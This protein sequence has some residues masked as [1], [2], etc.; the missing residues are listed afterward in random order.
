MGNLVNPLG[1]WEIGTGAETGWSQ[2]GNTAENTRIYG[3]NPWKQKAVIWTSQWDGILTGTPPYE[4]TGEGESNADGGFLSGYVPCDPT[5]KYRFSWWIN[6]HVHGGGGYNYFGLYTYN[7]SYSSQANLYHTTKS[8]STNHYFYVPSYNTLPE[9]EWIL[10]VAHLWPYGTVSTTNDPTSGRYKLGS[11]G[12][13]YANISNDMDF[14]FDTTSYIRTRSYMYYC[15]RTDND[16]PWETT[17][18]LNA[19]ARTW[20][21]WPRIDLVD[22]TEPTIQ[23]LLRNANYQATMLAGNGLSLTVQCREMQHRG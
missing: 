6:R 11:G 8:S 5:K 12:V 14:A 13:K 18:D 9:N 10:I 4:D 7:S 16:P 17:G 20:W 22:G 2:N 23:Q 21:Y 1:Q 3:P 19:E 15:V